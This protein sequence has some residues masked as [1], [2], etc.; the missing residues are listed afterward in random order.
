M[1]DADKIVFYV[2][3]ELK[4]REREPSVSL[5]PLV[6][7]CVWMCDTVK[8]R[9]QASPDW[10]RHTI[11]FFLSLLVSLKMHKKFYN[12]YAMLYLKLLRSNFYF[13]S[14]L[15]CIKSEYLAGW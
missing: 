7:S 4:E 6:S 9:Q 10:S 3:V 2:R 8:H 5:F 14:V 11:H 1:Y 15:K 13:L 12:T